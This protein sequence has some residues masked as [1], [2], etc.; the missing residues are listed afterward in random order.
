MK[1]DMQFGEDRRRF[2][3]T[4]TADGGEMDADFGEVQHIGTPGKSAYEIALDNGFEGTEEEWLES[5]RGKDGPQGP[6]GETGPQ[7]DPGADGVSPVITVNELTLSGGRKAHDVVITDVNGE[8]RFILEDGEDGFSPA[9]D[10]IPDA[11][12]HNVSITSAAG[13]RRFY[14]SN[15]RDGQPGKDGKDGEDGRTPIKGIDYFDGKDGPAYTLTAAD[16]AEITAAVVAAL[17]VYDGSVVE[18]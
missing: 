10:V 9:V 12:G 18:V 1:L 6:R 8:K 2:A 5:L 15:G 17:P 11:Y 7:G 4:M 16:K 14:I 13:T 3:M